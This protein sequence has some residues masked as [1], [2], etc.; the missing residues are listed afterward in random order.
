MRER[1]QPATEAVTLFAPEATATG[2]VTTERQRVEQLAAEFIDWLLTGN[3]DGALLRRKV[4]PVAHAPL[5][6]LH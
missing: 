4:L 3:R 2:T 5:S 6:R 1:I